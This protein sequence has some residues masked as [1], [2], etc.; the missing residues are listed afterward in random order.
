LES[1]NA[2]K[3]G[4]NSFVVFAIGWPSVVSACQGMQDRRLINADSFFFKNLHGVWQEQVGRTRLNSQNFASAAN[5]NV[6]VIHGIGGDDRQVVFAF[7]IQ[8]DFQS[9]G[10]TDPEIHLVNEVVVHA[11]IFGRKHFLTSMPRPSMAQGIN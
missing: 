3:N 2:A 9:V 1:G 7:S 10:V 8:N 4:I 5:S 11:L 6:N